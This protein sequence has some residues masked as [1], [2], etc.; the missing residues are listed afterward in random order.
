M[1]DINSH[2]LPGTGEAVFFSLGN[3]C[4]FLKKKKNWGQRIFLL[5]HFV[6]IL[7]LLSCLLD[8]LHYS[9]HITKLGE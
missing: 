5:S 1:C 4:K 8:E 3:V 6:F 7:N 2:P 9:C